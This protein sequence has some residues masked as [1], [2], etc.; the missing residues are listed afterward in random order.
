M[1][2]SIDLAHF[3]PLASLAGGLLIGAAA[4]LFVLGNGRVAGIS[5]IVGGIFGT[6][7]GE[8]AWRLAFLAGLLAAPWLWRIAAPL[9]APVIAASPA[10]LV[11]AGLFVGI[12]TRYAS[13]CT[14]GHGVCG[15]ARGSLRSFVATG[16]FMAAGFATVYVARHLAGA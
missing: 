14:S 16:A 12:G 1:S 4:A 11:C 13:G 10:T 7:R 5:G 6:S 15:I 3:T 9:P 8:R 2:P